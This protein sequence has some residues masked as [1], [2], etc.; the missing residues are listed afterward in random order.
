MPSL[1]R[2]KKKK[3]GRMEEILKREE[4]MEEREL[5]IENKKCG[6]WGF[7]CISTGTYIY[8]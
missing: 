8:V 7:Y 3:L 5:K 1:K 4:K 6:V 2:G